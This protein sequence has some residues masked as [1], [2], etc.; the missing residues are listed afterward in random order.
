[1]FWIGMIVGLIIGA[2][3][4]YHGLIWYAQKI[5]GMSIDEMGDCGRLLLDA[6][7]N[8]ESTIVVYHDGMEL[9]SVLL[10]EK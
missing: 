1:M 3:V 5:S 10:E 6:S 2:I 9:N 4:I 8:R 7:E